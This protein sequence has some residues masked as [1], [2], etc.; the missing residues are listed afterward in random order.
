MKM[1]N[2]YW[3]FNTVIEEN[4]ILYGQKPMQLTI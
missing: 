3:C 2:K 4:K 1:S